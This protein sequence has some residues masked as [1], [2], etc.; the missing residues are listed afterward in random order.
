MSGGK[1]DSPVNA[2]LV[3]RVDAESTLFVISARVGIQ[4]LFLVEVRIW[5]PAAVYPEVCEGPA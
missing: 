4:V 1:S 3:Q 5:M 2:R